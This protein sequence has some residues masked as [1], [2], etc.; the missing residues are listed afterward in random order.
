MSEYVIRS[1]A[2]QLCTPDEHE[3]WQGVKI[4][5]AKPQVDGTVFSGK[6]TES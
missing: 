6:S 3:Q 2:S 5:L 1:R 4:G